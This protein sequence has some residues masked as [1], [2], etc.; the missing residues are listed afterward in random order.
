[1]NIIFTN[2]WKNESIPKPKPSIKD[3]P[4]WYKKM[5]GLLPDSVIEKVGVADPTHPVLG[6]IKHCMPVF[7]SLSA[8][9]L[10]YSPI[11][12]I[13][14]QVDGKPY[15]EWYSSDESLLGWHPKEQA[16][17]HPLSN[18]EMLP[19]WLNPWS[20]ETPEGYS[21]LFMHP[22]HREDLPFITMS[23]IVDTDAYTAPVA[24]PFSFKNPSSEI[25]IP[26][27]TPICQVIPFKRDTWEMKIGLI[28]NKIKAGNQSWKLRKLKQFRY[29]YGYWN[30]KS[31]K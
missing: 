23:G 22:M 18:T 30:R 11:D 7:D 1:M 10:L 26:A 17:L 25:Y 3:M 8:G 21:C 29:K 12:L 31:F 2:L 16:E 15:Y 14:S 5:E 4:E 28:E 9:Y 27:G 20:I 24:L 6:S 19:K 13:V